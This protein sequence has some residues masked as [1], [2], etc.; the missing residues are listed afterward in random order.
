MTRVGTA[1]WAAVE[2]L[3][4]QPYNEKV[5]IY[6]YGVVWWECLTRKKPFS[7]MSPARVIAAVTLEHLRLPVPAETP[8]PLAAIIK[9]MWNTSP[10]K[11]PSSTEILKALREIFGER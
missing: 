1:H 2:L 11:R 5:D 7:S 8:P 3:L 4:G 10:A 9:R 6:S